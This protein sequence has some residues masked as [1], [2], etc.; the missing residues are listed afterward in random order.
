M[1]I[2][3]VLGTGFFTIKLLCII[4]YQSWMSWRQCRI[5]TWSLWTRPP[6]RVFGN[7]RYERGTIDV[8]ETV[9]VVFGFLGIPGN[10]NKRLLVMYPLLGDIVSLIVPQAN[11]MCGFSLNACYTLRSCYF[12]RHSILWHQKRK[13]PCWGRSLMSETTQF[14]L[15]H[16][17]STQA[18][19]NK[20]WWS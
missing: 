11:S 1:G 12:T 9:D 3:T 5:R 20:S 15:G 6:L 18:L 17:S 2:I 8:F 10:F 7:H 14:F 13:N 16:D 19:Y 4:L